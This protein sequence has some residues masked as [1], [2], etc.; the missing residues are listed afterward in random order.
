MENLNNQ[1]IANLYLIWEV[2][3]E[4]SFERECIEKEF[5]LR[6]K[7]NEKYSREE[8]INLSRLHAIGINF[9]PST[10]SFLIYGKQIVI[11]A[12]VSEDELIKIKS[13]MAQEKTYGY[14][15]AKSLVPKMLSEAQED[16]LEKIGFHTSEIL[17]IENRI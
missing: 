1:S 12:L 9:I 16:R 4:G 11:E 3:K 8:I 5:Q 15:K 13:N 17:D 14:V 10:K 2:T 6:V 7:T